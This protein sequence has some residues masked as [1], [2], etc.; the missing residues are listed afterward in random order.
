ML[1]SSTGNALF[2]ILIAVALFAALS[3]AVTNSGR[4]GSGISKEQGEIRASRVIETLGTYQQTIQRLK[5]I[6]GYDQV[7]FNDTAADSTGTCYNGATPVSSC[8][9]VGLFNAAEGLGGTPFTFDDWTY[10][11]GSTWGWGATYR[12]ILVSG[13]DLGTTAADL[14]IWIEPVD[15]FTCEAFNRNLHGDSSPIDFSEINMLSPTSG[16][17]MV[18]WSVESGFSGFTTDATGSVEDYPVR[19]GGYVYDWDGPVHALMY[20]MEEN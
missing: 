18:E 5:I 6:G 4:G 20:V 8:S 9:T 10:N 12:Q 13:K 14:L 16:A 3:Y 7:H 11:N 2:L 1:R 19:E 15:K 17:A